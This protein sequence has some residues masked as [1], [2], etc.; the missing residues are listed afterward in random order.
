MDDIAHGTIAGLKPL[1]YEIINLGSNTPVVLMDLIHI[2]EDLTGKRANIKFQDCLPANVFK[3]W[4]DIRKAKRLL[5]WQPEVT[6][7]EGMREVIKWYE[8]NR[9]WVRAIKA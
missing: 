7:Q 6:L 9:E 8:T 2:V 5:A 4:A 1:G 3:T